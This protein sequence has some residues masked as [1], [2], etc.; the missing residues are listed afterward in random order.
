MNLKDGIRRLI[1]EPFIVIL[2]I[3]I[4]SIGGWQAWQNLPVD[5][6]PNVGE[7]QVI[8]YADWPG[9]SPKDVEDQI[10]YPLSV[11]MLGLPGAKS[12]RGRSMLGYSFVQVTFAEDRDLYWA[13]SRVTEKL[14]TVANQLPDGVMPNMGPDATALGQIFHY[15]L[16]PGDRQGS[17]LEELRNMQDYVVK[18]A[19]ESVE[20]VSEVASIGGH[21][22]SY[23]IEL[24]PNKLKFQDLP[25]EQV[26][27]ALQ[28][29]NQEL[30][31]RTLEQ[32]GMEFI[33]RAKGYLGEGQGAD[34]V[35][36]DIEETI[37]TSR[38][39]IPVRIKD[40]GFVN[41]G[42]SF[43]QGAL[44]LNGKEAVGGV[45]VM[46]L[47]EKPQAVIDRVKEKIKEIEPALQGVKIQ[48]IYDRTNL[49][50]ETIQTLTRALTEEILIT[51]VVIM[52]FLLNLRASLI[53]S[54]V[55]PL[56]VLVAF[57]FM[58]LMNLD[59]N[60]MSLAGIAIAIGN[61][62]DMAIVVT[63][64]IYRHL[65]I[66][67]SDGQKL[68]A[69]Q[70]SKVIWEGSSEVFPAI[71]T[72]TMTTVISF[73]PVFYLTG[74]DGK[75]FV[76]L[77]W[78]KSI[79][80]LVALLITVAIIPALCRIFL[81]KNPKT[82]G[83]AEENIVT[84]RIKQGY[85][86]LLH[87]ALDHPRLIT[88]I[89][90]ALFF[91]GLF[92][93]QGIRPLTWPLQ[94]LTGLWQEQASELLSQ[95]ESALPGIP[96][97]D[98]IPLDEGSFFYMPTLYPAVSFQ[99][100]LHILQT[101]GQL[102]RQIPEVIDV[103][104]KIGRV[105]SALDPA[106]VSMI[107]TYVTLKAPDQ[108]RAG[109]SRRE[110][111]REINE[112]ATLP[113]ITQASILQPIEGRVVM[114]QSGIRAPM[115]IRIYGDNLHELAKASQDIG[116]VLQGIPEIDARTVN[117]DLVLG[118]PYAEFEIDRLR[119][120]RFGLSVKSIQDT[121]ESTIAGKHIGYTIEGRQR[122]PIELR[123]PLHYR[124]N[125]EALANIPLVTQSGEL[126]RMKDLAH[127]ETSWGPSMI[128]SENGLLVAHVSFS[129]TGNVGAL[130]TVDAATAGIQQALQDKQINLPTGYRW[131]AVGSFLN[132]LEA[133]KRLALL[134]PLAVII[135]FIIIYLS[136]RSVAVS[137]IIFT[138]IPIAFGGGMLLLA[139]SGFQ[140]NT[141]VWVGFIAVF[142]I[143]VD[144]GVLQATYIK[145]VFQ[146]R[147][148]HSWSDIRQAIEEA[149]MM[150]VR[151]CIMTTMTTLVA[152]L[153]VLLSQGT[154]ADV[155]KAMA[156]PIFGGMFFA[157]V[158]LLVVPVIYSRYHWFLLQRD[159]GART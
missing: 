87:W 123:Y 63:E 24:D 85:R 138:G 86:P 47:G 74:R 79:T 84:R 114:L 92:L 126:L 22:R 129:G 110:L 155:A 9:R 45:V 115:A 23:Q 91:I 16:L 134:I 58:N 121:I 42:T 105:E 17:N 6:I 116:Q 35:V 83:E 19:L 7:N 149:A 117:P 89:P 139:I 144:D 57:L 31:A 70:R 159:K 93:W 67:E 127:M 12:V 152:L 133:N 71:T 18:Y 148:I 60:I 64:N 76:P 124:Q 106:P 132:Q 14:T 98:W 88:M 34:A 46:R 122:F 56:T 135:N 136:F 29:A 150:R 118:S 156:I 10:T 5:A 61:I 146:Q 128:S 11:A 33:I 143:A 104:G 21:I 43:R 13:R 108:W 44:D 40:L 75:L 15:V 26:V 68:N 100:A 154:G 145:S 20:G 142:G 140:I 8:V 72:A 59:A 36:Q 119:S 52:I 111:W 25:L 112:I 53:V 157:L 95:A 55:L 120:A 141:A 151:P 32:S 158:V 102:I 82:E 49:I 73:L 30:S 101:Q 37:V 54:L 41:V 109:L 3:V 48:A 27:A 97:D 153:P 96:T 99:Q 28:S 1:D 103:L 90:L 78:T 65:S 38:S 94:K 130:R 137:L 125:L 4:I 77:A 69:K 80:L 107:E 113:G 2:L 51:F 39:G 147:D 50:S 131:E 66:A 81:Q 62:V